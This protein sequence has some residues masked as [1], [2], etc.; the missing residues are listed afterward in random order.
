MTG[1]PSAGPASAAPTL[2]KP[3]SICFSAANEV[4][5]PGF[6]A[7][8]PAELALPACARA[9]PLTANGAAAKAMATAPRKRRR[10]GLGIGSEIMGL[11]CISYDQIAHDRNNASG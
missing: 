4:W 1:T 2:R 11:S 9:V 7:L 10:L 3:A 5:P 6:T 8:A